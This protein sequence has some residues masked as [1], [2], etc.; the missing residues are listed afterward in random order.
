[1]VGGIAEVIQQRDMIK[2][3]DK[4]IS[5]LK[6]EIE[7][8]KAEITRNLERDTFGNS[9]KR[10]F[11]LSS[12]KTDNSY[13]ESVIK[14]AEKEI[15][16]IKKFAAGKKLNKTAIAKKVGIGA[17]KGTMLGTAIALP[18]IALVGLVKL[19]KDA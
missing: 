6:R 17:F 7:E 2:N 14:T 9:V 15:D 5:P 18:I 4:Y 12:Q 8:A 10:K 19:C 1:M 16:K 13:L 11:G 3:S